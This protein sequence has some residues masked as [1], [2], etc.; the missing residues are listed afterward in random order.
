MVD[1]TEAASYPVWPNLGSSVL[2]SGA[3]GNGISRL[4]DKGADHGELAQ[5]ETLAQ[6]RI[7]ALLKL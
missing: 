4:A 2:A 5:V 3:T 1:Q 6:R 7:T